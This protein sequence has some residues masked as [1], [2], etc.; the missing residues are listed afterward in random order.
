MKEVRIRNQV[1]EFIL[2]GYPHEKFCEIIDLNY[3]VVK[4]QTTDDLKIKIR[5]L[6]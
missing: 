2:R 4:P 1:T 5:T 6:I 3:T